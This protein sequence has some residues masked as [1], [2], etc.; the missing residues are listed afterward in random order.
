LSG[1]ESLRALSELNRKV[2][3]SSIHTS[4]DEKGHNC[5]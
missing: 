4:R 3:E 2:R 1:Y 5:D